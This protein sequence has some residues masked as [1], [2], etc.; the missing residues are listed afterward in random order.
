MQVTLITNQTYPFNNSDMKNLIKLQINC[1]M[2]TIFSIIVLILFLIT[3]VILHSV[4]GKEI[5]SDMLIDKILSTGVSV[6]SAVGV[7]SVITY[8]ICEYF[9]ILKSNR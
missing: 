2:I 9:K 3:G 8:L 4:Y 6:C 5:L 7:I 1:F